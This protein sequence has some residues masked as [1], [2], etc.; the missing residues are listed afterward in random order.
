MSL[1]EFTGK[2]NHGRMNGYNTIRTDQKS[3]NSTAGK[4]EAK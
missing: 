3:F 2:K 4:R 1:C